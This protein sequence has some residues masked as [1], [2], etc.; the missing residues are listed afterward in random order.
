MRRHFLFTLLTIILVAVPLA[1]PAHTAQAGAPSITVPPD[2][3]LIDSAPGVDLY[4][5]DYAGGTPDYVMVVDLSKEAGI[6]LLHG[7]VVDPGAGSG[8]FGGSN[9]TLTRQSLQQY[10]DAFIADTADAVCV[11]NGA[12]FSTDADPTALAF[13][14]KVDGQIL[15]EGYARDEFPDQKR[16][17][18]IWPD[19]ARIAIMS[20]DS[21][22]ASDAPNI[23]S[24]LAE[25]ANK[26][27][28]ALI[29]RTFAGVVDADGNGS[30]ETVLFI[31]S[32]TSRAA[33]TAGV[34]RA[35]GAT[36]VMMLDGGDSA[37]MLCNNQ[38]Q[39]YSARTIPQAIGITAGE[40]AAYA[41]KVVRQSDW[42]IVVQG[43]TLDV[44]LTL[45]NAGSETWQLGEVALLNQR[46]DW[47]A[48]DRMAMPVAVA[49]G[50][51]VTLNWTNPIFE[52]TGVFVSQWKIA[53]G[54]QEFSDKPIL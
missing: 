47:G 31:S 42:E 34:L 50:A 17:L 2:F 14:L 38:P 37:Q 1:V 4:R 35:F 43:K 16:M 30:Q 45:T 9:P 27:S 39:V 22:A 20:A 41:M 53:R 19:H 8:A 15:S 29:G 6:Q 21:L 13:P 33:E 26:D 51:N 23:L 28:S 32:K 54:S 46:N 5:K 49:P 36:D 11:V 25:D 7:S 3:I 18:E 48:G 40:Q 12:F 44:E 10:W 24:G 52:K